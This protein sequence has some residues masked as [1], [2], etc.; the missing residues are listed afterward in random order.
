MAGI[1]PPERNSIKKYANSKK[2]GVKFFAVQPT[3][4]FA[5]YGDGRSYY[6][7]SEKP[8]A[9]HV[10]IMKKQSDEGKGLTGYI[11]KVVRRNYKMKLD[12]N[13]LSNILKN[14]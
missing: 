14:S 2:G 7:D 8:G 10:A 11:N 12:K 13:Y 9:E 6:Y 4:I 1:E 3:S 5:E